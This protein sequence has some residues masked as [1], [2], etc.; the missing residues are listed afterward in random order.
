MSVRFRLWN[1]SEP[2][3]I[4]AVLPFL[5]FFIENINYNPVR[6]VC[7]ND[8]SVIKAARLHLQIE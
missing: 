8:G 6:L 7:T 5:P 1:K 2:W 3:A 4:Y